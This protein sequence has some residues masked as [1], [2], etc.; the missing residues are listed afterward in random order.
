MIW[1]LRGLASLGQACAPA[2]A[3]Y[4]HP[5]RQ[6][7]IALLCLRHPCSGAPDCGAIDHGN[8]YS[9]VCQLDLWG[10]NTYGNQRFKEIVVNN[11]LP[12]GS[13][14]RSSGR[15]NISMV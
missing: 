2:H 1:K 10:Q 11:Y 14:S 8:L 13:R 7:L 6:L 4:L 3:P 15:A 12:A 9:M 5:C